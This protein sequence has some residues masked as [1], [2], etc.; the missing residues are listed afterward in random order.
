A[1][2]PGTKVPAVKLSRRLLMMALGQLAFARLA[3][4]LEVEE[5]I[6]GANKRDSEIEGCYLVRVVGDADERN[7]AERE[8]QDRHQREQ[9]RFVRKGSNIAAPPD[10]GPPVEKVRG[11]DGHPDP[12]D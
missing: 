3:S 11:G 10:E 6:A 4:V 9:R 8:G 7:K 2:R 12:D 1:S 5:G